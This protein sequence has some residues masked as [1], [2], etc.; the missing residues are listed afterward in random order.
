MDFFVFAFV[1]LKT[2][3]WMAGWMDAA[4]ELATNVT[5]VRIR[6]DDDGIGEWYARDVRAGDVD[7]EDDDEDGASMRRSASR[8][9]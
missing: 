6:Y 3:R 1:F 7:D 9:W 2:L 8:Q 4:R 5:Y